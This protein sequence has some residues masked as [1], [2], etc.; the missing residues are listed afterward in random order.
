MTGISG[1]TTGEMARTHRFAFFEQNREEDSGSFGEP[2]SVPRPLGV[3][4]SNAPILVET[5][6]R[7]GLAGFCELARAT[8]R[9]A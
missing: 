4:S 2:V 8:A 5:L 1:D 7:A 9:K 3:R 6:D